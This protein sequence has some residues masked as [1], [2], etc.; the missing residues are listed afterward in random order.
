MLSLKCFKDRIHQW[1]PY[2]VHGGGVGGNERIDEYKNLLS[3]QSK[4]A[5]SFA[6]QLVVLLL[7]KLHLSF[8]TQLLQHR[9]S[10][11]RN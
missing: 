5:K 9:D 8:Q 4:I 7:Q 11:R 3:F 6:L 1:Y 2:T 10:S